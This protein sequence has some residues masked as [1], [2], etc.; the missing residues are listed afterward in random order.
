MIDANQLI[1]NLK[2][3][4]YKKG[5]KIDELPEIKAV[6]DLLERSN[7]PKSNFLMQL[8][9]L[10]ILKQ[11]NINNT[12]A[13]YNPK[14]NTITYVNEIDLIHELFHMAS[15]ENEG[16]TCG[17]TQYVNGIVQDED[18]TQIKVRYGLD[19]GITDM[20]A[21]MANSNVP[22]GY[23]FERMCAEMLRNIFGLQIFKG[24][25]ENSYDNLSRDFPEE[26][27]DLVEDL[28]STLDEYQDLT[29]LIYS[30]DSTIEDVTSL[31]ELTEYIMETLTEIAETMGKEKS[32]VM[33]FFS[34]KANDSSMQSIRDLVKFDNA[35][36]N[37]SSKGL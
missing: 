32:E 25:F 13:G 28:V 10:I 37:I 34:E 3:Q 6:Y 27:Q 20:F 30:G 31:E 16:K 1:N 21:E 15:T 26:V 18:E 33:T 2:S 23:P 29:K 12:A 11:E 8:Q 36:Q 35:I 4:Y 5:Y 19:E 24:Y 9:N 14:T 17:I 22:C 7:L